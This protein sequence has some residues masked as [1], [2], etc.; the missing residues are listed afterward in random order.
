[1]FSGGGGGWN[2]PAELAMHVSTLS[3][4]CLSVDSEV[5]TYNKEQTKYIQDADTSC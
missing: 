4:V 5:I 1:M 3:V 2:L